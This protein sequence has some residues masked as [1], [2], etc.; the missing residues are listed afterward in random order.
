ML[1]KLNPWMNLLKTELVV[2]IVCDDFADW[3]HADWIGCLFKLWEF[4]AA[5]L[6]DGE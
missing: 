6:L 3:S 5:G 2:F 1:M 4:A